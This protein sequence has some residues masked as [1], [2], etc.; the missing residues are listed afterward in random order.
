MMEGRQKLLG[1]SDGKE[2][3]GFITDGMSNAHI[4]TGFM[5]LLRFRIRPRNIVVYTDDT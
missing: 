1:M 4:L 3:I 5:L 2:I